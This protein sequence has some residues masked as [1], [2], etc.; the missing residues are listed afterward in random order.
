MPT[1]SVT[2]RALVLGS[3]VAIAA[4]AITRAQ[5]RTTLRYIPPVD[6]SFLDPHFSSAWVVRNHAYMVFDT[7]YGQNGNFESSPQMAEGHTVEDDGKLWRITLRPG[8]LWH[9][10]TPVLARD[11]VAS[12]RRWAARDAYGRTLM[13]ATDELSAPDDRTI[14]FRLK[15]PFPSLADALGKVPTFTCM[16]MPERL[17]QT[18]PFKQIPE[19]IGSGPYR[20]LP[21]ERVPGA[22]NAYARF[23]AYRPREGG[24]PDW[25]AGPKVAHFDRVEWT[26]LPDAATAAAALAAGEQDWW[27]SPALDLLPML[28]RRADVVVRTTDHG[29]NM[30][31]LR[32]NCLVPPFD[33]P[34][35]RRAVLAAI[36]Q[37][38]FM[39]AV[40]SD[41][42]LV[43]LP[44][45]IFTPGTPMASGAGMEVLTGPRNFARA[46][47]MLAESGYKGER[48]VLMAPLD[49]PAMKAA[50][51]VAADMLKKLGMNIDY[52]VTDWGTVLQR[53]AKTEPVEQGGWSIYINMQDGIGWT[54]PAVHPS[55]RGTGRSAA[56]GWPTSPQLEALRLEF[57]DAPDLGARK[58]ISA[59]VQ[60]Q[61]FAD[62]PFMPVGA[63]FQPTAYRRNLQGVLNGFP[64][65]WNV[66]RDG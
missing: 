36:D 41:A 27:D 55:T 30:L 20:F 18:D 35:V 28:K 44:L 52:A 45:G 48:T 22:R 23:A 14:R 16:M 10:N 40:T 62:V 58:A 51:D 15:R 4:P 59:R 13:E 56:P 7:L 47:K 43:N 37:T 29:G 53:R 12:I 31:L 26:T 63:F 19:V 9:D 39:Q 61:A 32:P 1:T 42:S 50:G 3:A 17:A 64:T 33:N 8:L 65:F 6:L 49:Y 11:C 24:T 57:F 5:S 66:R 46:R 25:T 38:E 2:R 34:L 54:N 60:L 21:D